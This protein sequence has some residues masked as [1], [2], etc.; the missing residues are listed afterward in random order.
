MKGVFFKNNYKENK[1]Y[2][3]KHI[4][5]RRNKKVNILRELTFF[6]LKKIKKDIK[7]IEYYNYCKFDHFFITCTIL[8]LNNLNY[9]PIDSIKNIDIYAIKSSRKGKFSSKKI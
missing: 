8:K 6:K 7:T 3:N 9:I 2:K 4:Y 5:S 1:I